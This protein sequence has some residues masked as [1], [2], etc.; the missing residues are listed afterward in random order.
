VRS[1]RTSTCS[2]TDAALAKLGDDSVKVVDLPGHL[3][4]LAR[5]PASG[6]EDRETPAAVLVAQPTRAGLGGLKPQL[7]GVKAPGTVEILRRQSGGDSGVDERLAADGGGRSHECL[8]NAPRHVMPRSQT[9]TTPETHREEPTPALRADAQQKFP[10]FPTNFPNRAI[11]LPPRS[12]LLGD[13]TQRSGRDLVTNTAG[14][15]QG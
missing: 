7:L 11:P 8:L 6:L 10:L 15:K 12:V 14:R 2:K 13:R 5:W 4:V 1:P 9:P 3:G